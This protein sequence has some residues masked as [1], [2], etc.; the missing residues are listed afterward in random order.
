MNKG[1]NNKSVT[2]GSNFHFFFFSPRP[3][4]WTSSDIGT[5]DLWTNCSIINGGY[6]CDGASAGGQ[7][8]LHFIRWIMMRMNDHEKRAEC[9]GGSQ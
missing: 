6:R 1:V 5:S 4:A 8:P 2:R 9:N 7:S 3:Q